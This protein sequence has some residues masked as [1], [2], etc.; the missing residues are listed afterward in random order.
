MMQSLT[1]NARSPEAFAKQLRIDAVRMVAAAHASHIGGCLSAADLLAHVYGG[2]LKIDP[3]SPR[4]EQRDRFFLS[5]GHAAAILYA[6]LAECGF[7]PVVEL[8]SYCKEGSRLTGHVTTSVPGVELSTGSLGHALAVACGVA[9]AAKRSGHQYR[10][11]V[12]LSDGELDEGSNWEAIL[13]AGHHKLD[14]LIA[15]VDYNAIQ[16]FGR[17]DEVLSLD[18]LADKF[19][20]FGWTPKEIDGHDHKQISDALKSLPFASGAPSVLIAHTIK[21][22]GIDF[23]ENDLAWHYRSPNAEQLERALRELER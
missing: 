11:V 5:K 14:N 3:Q 4:W 8:G 13:F 12:L 1:N 7:F 20:S 9:L 6:A 10:A 22:K 16:S 21:G 2:F 17:V 15:I 23:M 19:R 18:P